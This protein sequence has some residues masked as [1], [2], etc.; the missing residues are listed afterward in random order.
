LVVLLWAILGLTLLP[1]C[2]ALKKKPV[3]DKVYNTGD[4][5]EEIRGQKV[6]NPATGRYEDMKDVMAKMDT[7]RWKE[8]PNPGNPPITSSTVLVPTADKP[9]VSSPT[10]PSAKT[11][12]KSSYRMSM[13]LP[14][15]T[16]AIDS[17]G[18]FHPSS[19]WAI[20]FY[21][22]AQVAFDRLRQEGVSLEVD[23]FD[24]N[25]DETNIEKLLRTNRSLQSADIVIG[26]YKRDHVTMVADYFKNRNTLVVSPY[27]ASSGLSSQNPNYVQINPALETHCRAITRFVRKKYPAEQVVVVVK[28]TSTEVSRLAFFQDENSKI[29]GTAQGKKMRELLAPDPVTSLS[30]TEITSL[31]VPN[32]TTVFIMPSFSDMKFVNQFLRT[33]N[34]VKGTNQVLVVGMPQWLDMENPDY[35]LFTSLNLHLSSSFFLEPDSYEVKAFRQNFYQ[36]FG[37]LPENEAYTGYDITLYFG[38]MLKKYGTLPQ[39]KFALETKARYLHTDFQIEPNSVS[40]TGG[41]ERKPVVNQYE[42]KAIF[43][44]KFQDMQFVR[45][46]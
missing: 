39:E 5:L 24:T 4:T 13:L 17:M 35:D 31:L 22:G 19:A 32:K 43:I 12:F 30:T 38:R 1:S 10:A 45:A 29:N 40:G 14:F 27:S 6:Y 23:V 11:E 28:N 7:V 37:S 34:T 26:P 21:A 16:D 44:L 18:N 46:E 9:N 20:Q 8:N 36:R 3:K 42:N 15:L 2:G 41:A 33:L 25:A